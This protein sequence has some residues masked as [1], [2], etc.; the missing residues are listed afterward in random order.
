[1]TVPKQLQPK[2]IP[3]PIAKLIQRELALL[4]KP[5]A[6]ALRMHNHFH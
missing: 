3:A 1:M 2:W 5:V 4:W 6:A